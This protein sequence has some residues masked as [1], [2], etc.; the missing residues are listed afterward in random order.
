MASWGALG[1][2]WG[3]LLTSHPT[4]DKETS[5]LG[6]CS[7]HSFEMDQCLMC[8]QGC[9]AEQVRPCKG[10]AWQSRAARARR[11]FRP[12]V[13]DFLVQP[14]RKLRPKEGR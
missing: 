7:L 6:H 3:F 8:T 4:F 5:F 12:F 11:D 14:N 9:S 1:S 13:T 2:C 10:G